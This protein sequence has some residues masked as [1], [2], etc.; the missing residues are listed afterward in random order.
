MKIVQLVPTLYTGD[1]VGND[2]IA[3]YHLL[4][5]A[6]YETR[7]YAEKINVDAGSD[8]V[9]F[10]GQLSTMT[11]EDWILYHFA[12]GNNEMRKLLESLPCHKAMI[13][14]NITPSVYFAPYDTTLVGFLDAGRQELLQIKNLFFAVIA[15]SYYNQMELRGMGYTC[16]IYVLPILIP[17]EDYRRPASAEVLQKYSDDGYKNF[18]FVGRMAPHKKIEDIIRAYAHYKKRYNERSRL[19][20]VGNDE[21]LPSYSERLRRYVSD[22]GLSLTDDVIFC[23]HVPFEHILAY[24]RLA[25]VFICMSEHEGFCVPLAEAMFFN[26]PIIAYQAAAVPETM[27]N[28]GLSLPRKDSA[29]VAAAIH[30]V[31]TNQE[32]RE[33]MKKNAALRLKDFSYKTIGQNILQL[34][35]QLCADNYTFKLNMKAASD[36][37]DVFSRQLKQ[38]AQIADAD[39]GIVIERFEN[40]PVPNTG[41]W[42]RILK[43]WILKPGYK[44]VSA[45]APSIA[46]MVRRGV[47]RWC[48]QK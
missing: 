27:G 44:C 29:F 24:Y 37:D 30:E 38:F 3:I 13:Y 21:V 45:I 22:L 14:H 42:K 36:E 23:S 33:I 8:M 20:L 31:I 28:A 48:K 41:R 25:D 35:Q 43:Y 2:A 4:K 39:D 18:L 34:I 40:I 9:A 17:F 5:R 1:A 10:A 19:F 46:E 7:I 16:P 32:F 26:V 47:S 11:S 12:F 15:D 6:G